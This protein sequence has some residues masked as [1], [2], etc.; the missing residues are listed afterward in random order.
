MK[1]PLRSTS[2]L[3]HTKIFYKRKV[4]IEFKQCKLRYTFYLL[5]YRGKL[6]YFLTWNEVVHYDVYQNIFTWVKEIKCI[7]FVEQW[8]I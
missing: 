3:T 8:F 2:S 4:Y 5:I 7:E 1:Y 6:L